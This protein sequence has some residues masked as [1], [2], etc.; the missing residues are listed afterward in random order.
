MISATI[1]EHHRE[2]AYLKF[3]VDTDYC[4]GVESQARAMC[5]GIPVPELAEEHH[6]ND[7]TGVLA[8]CTTLQTDR[9]IPSPRIDQTLAKR[10]TKP[11]HRILVLICDDFGIQG[12]DGGHRRRSS[13]GLLN[14]DHAKCDECPL[15]DKV[16]A[17]LGHR[18]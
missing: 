12:S 9:H 5:E 4:R 17:I 14:E 2:C 16:N 6:A 3:T 15:A 10:G 8:S 13:F 7:S 1:F 18:F 11:R